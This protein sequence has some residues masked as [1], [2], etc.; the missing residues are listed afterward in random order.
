MSAS[1]PAR[2]DALILEIATKQEGVLARWQ[3]LERGLS[4][5]EIQYRLETGRL[6]A[7]HRGVYM[8]GPEIG[9]WRRERAAVLAC[10]AESWLG[11]GTAAAV[12]EL[13]AVPPTRP[14]AV[15]SRRDLRLT[16]SGIRV[17]RA[18]ALHDDEV[19]ESEGL[20]ITTP[21]RTLLDLASVAKADEVERALHRAIPRLVEPDAIEALLRRYPRRQGRRL[22]R[23]LLDSG[24]VPAVTR[25][26]AERA[27]LRLLRSGDL[28][29]PKTNVILLGYEVD[30]LW[31]AEKL[32]VEVDGRAFHSDARSFEG[33][34]DRDA[35]LVAAGY[36]VMRVTWK[37]IQQKPRPL[38]A[39]IAAA[40][41]QA[42]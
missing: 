26:E 15:I 31:R 41:A 4:P 40:L 18:S 27:L 11:Y 22:L 34:R 9:P 3:L 2:T 28:P 38:I 7:V 32:V 5:R 25:S 36:R 20:P 17:Y 10:G 23:M 24:A 30:C 42:G 37:Q 8:V 1:P 39:R 33:D 35:A 6:R 19:T 14:V 16:D 21:A 29:L 13:T 12:W